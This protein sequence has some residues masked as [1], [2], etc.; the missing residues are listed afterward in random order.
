M[1]ILT[2]LLV[3]SGFHLPVGAADLPDAAFFRAFVEEHCIDYHAQRNHQG[4]EN[5]L[6]EG[7]PEPG[8][9]EGEVV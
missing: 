7:V 2:G 4:L 1:T 9:L 5:Q 8:E 3:A 6:I